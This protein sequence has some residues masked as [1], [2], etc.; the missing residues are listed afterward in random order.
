MFP[1]VYFHYMPK[2]LAEFPDGVPSNSGPL[3]TQFGASRDGIHWERYDR[4]PFVRLGVKGEFD[5]K[6]ARVFYGLVPSRDGN[7]IYIYYSGGDQLHGWPG[8]ERHS[9]APKPNETAEQKTQSTPAA[10]AAAR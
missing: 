1:Q 3:D 9:T 2:Q 6:S 8:E 5:N 7:Q 4:Q 10:N